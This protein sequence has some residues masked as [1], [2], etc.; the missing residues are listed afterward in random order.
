VRGPTP[1]QARWFYALRPDPDAALR[2]GALATR[3]AASLGGRPLA[4]DD[5][6]LT[7]VFV[8]ERLVAD[9]TVLAGALAGLAST[10][11]ALALTR[12]G[13]FGRG[14]YWAGPADPQG[15]GE[16]G[17]PS[18]APAAPM[19]PVPW[20][21]A[22]TA[23]LQQRLRAAGVAFDERPLHLHA[24]LLRGARSH[25]SPRPEAFADALP[26]IPA[27]WTLALGCSG[28]GS[29]PQRRYRWRP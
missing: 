26:I 6:H 4:A 19:P 8:G 13:S 29:T 20:P 22:L 24:T 25:V 3:L 5:I 28:A 21:A 12:L 7:L 9:E 10:W 27:R 23:Q 14:L 17:G 2:L 1:P 11:P 18:P 15:A 16:A